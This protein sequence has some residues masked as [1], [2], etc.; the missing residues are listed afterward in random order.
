MAQKEKWNADDGRL[1]VHYRDN[2]SGD[3]LCTSL[4]P[5]LREQ[6]VYDEHVRKNNRRPCDG[7]HVRVYRIY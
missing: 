3:N 6:S 7:V 5:L 2:F 1:Y 4:L